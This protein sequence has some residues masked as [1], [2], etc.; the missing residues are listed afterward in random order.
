[1]MGRLRAR[2]IHA[3]GF[4][5]IEMMITLAVAAI[6]LGLSVPSFKSLLENNR[7]ASTANDLL[8]SLQYA[9]SE[10]VKRAKPAFLCPSTNGET[11]ID[12]DTDWHVG[13]IVVADLTVIAIG[14]TPDDEREFGVEGDG[15]R[16]RNFLA[17]RPR[18][19]T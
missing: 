19:L 7:A 6:L 15:K 9:R 3:E 10:A 1:M 2:V 13:W 5:L 17:A 14:A 4:T 8:A 11:C 12:G 16:S 18:N